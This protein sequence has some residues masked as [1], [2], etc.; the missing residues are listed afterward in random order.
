M[1]IIPCHA[2]L[3]CPL[4]ARG[5]WIVLGTLLIGFYS[6]VSSVIAQS[7]CL[8]APRL[9]TTMPMGGQA[10][11]EVEI[12]ITGQHI[13]DATDLRF[14]DPKITATP[15]LDASGQKLPNQYVVNIAPDCPAGI[16][17]ASVMTRL[18]LSASRVFSVGTL[19][20]TTQK[21]ST[22]T[23]PAAMALEVNSIC[24]AVMPARA[25]NHYSFQGKKDQ[26]VIVDCAAKG[27]DSKLNAVLIV[28]DAEGRDLV[29]ERR[30]GV[31]D[32]TPSEDGTFIIKVHEL[33]FKG[34]SDFFY[35]LAITEVDDQAE[36]VRL[37][38]T[39]SVNSFSWPPPGLASEVTLAEVEPN[40]QHAAAQ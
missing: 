35:R 1:N 12:T 4:P 28:A 21:Q 27:I 33:T 8:P 17:E 7:V 14:S 37:P 15:K 11:S 5:N 22:T 9:L 13:E 16:Y 32:F 34:G 29:V 24:N 6:C 18:G 25:I 20:E 23:V 30:G 19:S 38:S 31:I 2:T 10:G 26:R 40:G 39:R 36:I 3:P